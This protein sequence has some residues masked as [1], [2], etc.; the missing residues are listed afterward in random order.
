MV[1]SSLRDSS[2]AAK[3]DDR[4]AI[5]SLELSEVASHNE[6]RPLGFGSQVHYG[7]SDEDQRSWRDKRIGPNHLENSLVEQL[8]VCLLPLT[9]MIQMTF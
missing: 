9:C 1:G 5:D 8:D 3:L 4:V 2:L 6:D 7:R